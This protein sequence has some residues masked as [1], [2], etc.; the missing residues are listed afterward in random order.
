MQALVTGGAKGLG[1]CFVTWLA[2]QG[3]DVVIHCNRSLSE[4]K[5]LS[6]HI[7][8]KYDVKSIVWQADLSEKPGDQFGEFLQK[9]NI[10]IDILVNNIGDFLYKSIDTIISQDIHRVLHSNLYIPIELMRAC[11]PCMKKKRNGLIIN[12]TAADVAHLIMT[13]QTAWYH[14]AK[15]GVYMLT[16][17]WA[18]ELADTGITVNSIAPG[19]LPN[20]VY[21]DN[22][23]KKYWNDYDDVKT[24]FLKILSEYPDINGKDFNLAPGMFEAYE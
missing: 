20:S 16:Q 12:V 6:W 11:V 19:V 18:K 3:H 21:K 13:K 1:A 15:S 5:R 8:E 9:E 24:P 7:A 23:T 22:I 2:E 10:F 14:Y 17:L 4:A